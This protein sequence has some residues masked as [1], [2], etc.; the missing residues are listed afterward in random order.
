MILPWL[1]VQEVIDGAIRARQIDRTLESGPWPGDYAG[2][3]SVKIRLLVQESPQSPLPPG[4]SP[5][6]KPRPGMLVA[7]A[8][9]DI[10]EIQN[11]NE[12]IS[13]LARAAIGFDLKFHIRVEFGSDPP[14][15]EEAVAKINQ[16]LHEV[17][18]QLTLKPS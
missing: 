14:P 16:L 4:Y 11:L 8:P 12:Q 3:K 7:E 2:A 10:N 6:P 18:E 9:I 13:D 15:P 5:L 17:S 1:T